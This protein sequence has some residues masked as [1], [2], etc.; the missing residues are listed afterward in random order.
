MLSDLSAEAT[1]EAIMKKMVLGLMGGL[2][3]A[4]VATITVHAGG[5]AQWLVLDENPDSIFSYDTA[6]VAKPVDGIVRITARVVYTE[7]GKAQALEVLKPAKEYERLFES[8]YVYDL[9]CRGQK[10]RLINVTHHDEKG[11]Q[12]KAFDLS[13]VTEWEKIPPASRMELVSESVCVQ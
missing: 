11:K 9:N 6:S 7:D 8:R 12:L 4:L 10:S 13:A 2:I 3:M 1:R 5:A